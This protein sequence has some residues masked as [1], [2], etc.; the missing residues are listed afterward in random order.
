[1]R[2]YAL[3]V[4]LFLYIP[5]GIIVLFSA[6]SAGLPIGLILGLA[7]GYLVALLPS[8]C[9][10]HGI[11]ISLRGADA[12]HIKARLRRQP[13]LSPILIEELVARGEPI[14]QF[15]AYAKALLGSNSIVCRSCGRQIMRKWFPDRTP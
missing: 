10:R 3:A 5:I 8:D 6:A 9:V 4:Y 1:M 15:R 2:I 7:L 11:R 14:E 12:A 13:G